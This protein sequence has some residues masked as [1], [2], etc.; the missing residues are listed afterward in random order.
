MTWETL[1]MKTQRQNKICIFLCLVLI[2]NKWLD[3]RE[4]ELMVI[5]WGELRKASL[6]Q[7]F[8]ASE[9]RAGPLWSQHLMIYFQ[10]R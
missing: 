9:Y 2:K 5:N 3:Q 6:F 7:F 1:E 4:Y 10:G 8:L